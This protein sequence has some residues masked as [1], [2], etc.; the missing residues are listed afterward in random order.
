M[1]CPERYAISSCE[2]DVV[3]V[4]RQNIK[5][6]L[7]HFAMY[8]SVWCWCA[9]MMWRHDT[10][11]NTR[12]SW[13]TQQIVSTPHDCQHTHAHKH[14]GL[15][16][17]TGF[18]CMRL[19]WSS[20]PYIMYKMCMYSCAYTRSRE[21]LCGAQH[22]R[23]SRAGEPPPKDARFAC[24]RIGQTPTKLFKTSISANTHT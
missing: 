15:L 7:A 12:S 20:Q 18:K 22:K 16:G 21:I 3:V 9:Y 1:L 5:Y 10:C 2:S 6:S 17:K 11:T 14:A 19:W 13:H 8:A 24:S 4:W 23:Q